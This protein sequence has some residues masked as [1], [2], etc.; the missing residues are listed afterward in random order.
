MSK[1]KKKRKPRRSPPARSGY[2]QVSGKRRLPRPTR[3]GTK[4]PD[5]QYLSGY[6]QNAENPYVVAIVEQM[7]QVCTMAN[8]SPLVVFTDWVGMI[9]AAIR[10]HGENMRAIALTGKVIEDPPEVAEIFRRARER[11]LR[12]T[13]K[14]PAVYRQMHAA[15]GQAYASL[16]YCA[17]PGLEWYGQQ[18]KLSPDIIGQV[19]MALIK[20]GP[21]W[22]QYFPAWGAALTAARGLF[23]D[24]V[25]EMIYMALDEEFSGTYLDSI[26]D[27]EAW[28]DKSPVSCQSRILIGPS[29]I[30]SSVMMLAAAVQFPP[31]AVYGGFVEFVWGEGV[32]PLLVKMAKINAML[33]G[34]NGYDL[35]LAKIA[36]QIEADLRQQAE[37][38][39]PALPLIPSPAP[40]EDRPE[41]TTSRFEAGGAP[42]FEALFRKKDG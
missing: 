37:E 22:S 38:S 10:L 36:G 2:K 17:E 28:V 3:I 29:K 13:E 26:E 14:Y 24:G 42:T 35:E 21:E 40:Q 9:E 15:F 19:F 4:N 27:L 33:Y 32:D 25:E 11:Y 31:W 39:R 8:L 20:P 34:L 7:Q 6:P 16:I 18:L 30:N 1:R 23:P 5:C 12:A 41:T